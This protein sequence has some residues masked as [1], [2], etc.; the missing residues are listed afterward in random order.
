MHHPLW[1]AIGGLAAAIGIT[2]T[3]DATGYA[4][5]SALPL[6]PLTG[7]F[8]YLQ[9]LSATEIG[10]TWG[11]TAHYGLSIAYPILVLCAAAAIASVYDAIDTRGADWNK[12]ALNIGLMSS[13]G[14]LIVLLTEEGFFRGWLWRH[15]NE[16]A[17]TLPRSCLRPQSHSPRGISRRYPSIQASIFQQMRSLSTSSTRPSSA[18][19]SAQCA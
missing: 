8:W 17:I 12:V 15:S 3:M 7:L 16:R 19:F 18:L 2:T 1:P 9:R 14:S 6:L 10:L 11:R 5:F 13:T 4:M